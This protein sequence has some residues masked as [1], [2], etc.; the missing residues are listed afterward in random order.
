MKKTTKDRK[1]AALKE[2][3]LT[4]SSSTTNKIQKLKNSPSCHQKM[5]KGAA[6]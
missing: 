3:G 2:V 4:V 5:K 6:C 1:A